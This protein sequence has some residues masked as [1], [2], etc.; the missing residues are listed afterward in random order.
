MK[1]SRLPCKNV[2]L[3]G[4]VSMGM[5]LLGGNSLLVGRSFRLTFPVLMERLMLPCRHQ[6]CLCPNLFKRGKMKL[7]SKV[8]RIIYRDA[9]LFFLVAADRGDI[10]ALRNP[11]KEVEMCN[12]RA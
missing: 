5:I 7:V 10:L 3:S 8:T 4:L 2:F 12:Y 9:S 1:S 11:S 6:T